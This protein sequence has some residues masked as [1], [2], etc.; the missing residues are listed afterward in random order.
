[1]TRQVVTT[2]ALA[3]VVL[4]A[5]WA[6]RRGWRRRAARTEDAVP[7]LPQAPDEL[8]TPRLGPIEAVYVSTTREG[9]WLDRIAAH[10]LGVRSRAD[11]A[12]FDSGVRIAREGAQ[13]VFIPA[14]T[15]RGASTAPGIAGKVV[16]RD[17]LVVLTWHAPVPTTAQTT[18]QTTVRTTV[19]TEPGAPM[20][21][22]DTGLRPRHAAD[23]PLL[24]G[25]VTALIDATSGT[26]EQS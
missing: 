15:L 21:G 26:K 4:L 1:M 25:A 11:V 8:G 3:L 10:D 23:R 13:D 5:W 17:G 9:D 7:V 2:V 18:A 14:G 12:V 24:V 22:L 16:G 6:M 20:R 19:R